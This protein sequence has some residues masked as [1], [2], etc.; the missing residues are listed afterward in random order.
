MTASFFD[1]TGVKISPSL[2]CAD[3]A[4]LAG[5]VANLEAIGADMIH[6]DIMDAHFAPNMP[7]GLGALSD[8]RDR[9]SLPFDVHLMVEL[10]LIHI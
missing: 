5:E 8:L 6:L 7:M 3:Q 1:E 4:N 9:T 10:S 2:M